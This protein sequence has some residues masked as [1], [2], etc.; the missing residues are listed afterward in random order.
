MIDPVTTSLKDVQQRLLGL[1]TPQ[2]ILVGHSLNS[3]LQ[4]L[5]LTHPFIVD[6]AI[7]YPHPRGPPLKSSLK[8]LAQK[9]LGR[10]IQKGDGATGHDSIEDAR[11]CLGL[12][13][14]ECEK[15]PLWGTSETSNEPI[16]KRLSRSPKANSISTVEGQREGKVGA[17]VDVGGSKPGFRSMAPYFIACSSDAAMSDAVRRCVLGDTDGAYIPGDGVELTWA[18]FRS[19][20]KLRGWVSDNR[21]G[22]GSFKEPET[23]GNNVKAQPEPSPK[24]LDAVI[25]EIC[26]CVKEIRDFLPPCTLLMLYSGTGDPRPLVKLQE[27]Q[28]K[29][30]KEFNTKKWDELSVKWTDVEEQALKSACK[31]ARRG[32]GMMTVT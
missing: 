18:R 31:R 4:A 17:I 9:Y 15:G 5:K 13:R 10:E 27:M 16:F 23:N 32:L 24:E 20:E 12:V 3:D 25:S 22:I 7:L 21:G 28:R 30:K 29:F 19:L 26:R 8:W 1:L 2:S 11:A 6:T 14:Q